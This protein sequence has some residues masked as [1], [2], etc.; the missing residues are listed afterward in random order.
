MSRPFMGPGP[1]A[2]PH[3]GAHQPSYSS[4]PHLDTGSQLPPGQI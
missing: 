2:Q 3:Y 1:G 4:G